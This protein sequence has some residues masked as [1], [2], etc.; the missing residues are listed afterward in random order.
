MRKRNY[1]RAMDAVDEG[2]EGGHGVWNHDTRGHN[3]EMVNG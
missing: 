3:E 2:Q 1:K